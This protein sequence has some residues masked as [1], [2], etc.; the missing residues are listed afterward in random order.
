MEEEKPAIEIFDMAE[1]YFG[2]CGP[3]I[4]PLQGLGEAF[5]KEDFKKLLVIEISALFFEFL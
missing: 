3:A 4:R 5:E 2:G 1:K